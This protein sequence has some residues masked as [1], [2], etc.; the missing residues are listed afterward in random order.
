VFAFA[1]LHEMPGSSPFFSQAAGAM[2]PGATVLL[3]EPAGH[4]GDG[5]FAEELSAAAQAG[6]T[7]VGNPSIRKCRAALLRKP[8]N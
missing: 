4:V 3:A 8:A 2:K 6:F 1:V 5:E 7:A